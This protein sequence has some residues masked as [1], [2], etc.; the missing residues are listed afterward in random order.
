M[1]SE[2][3]SIDDVA[4]VDARIDEVNMSRDNIVDAVRV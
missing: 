3:V 4:N 1:V 2:D